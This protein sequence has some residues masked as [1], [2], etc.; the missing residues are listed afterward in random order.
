M[1]NPAYTIFETAHELVEKFVIHL[2]A[3][4]FISALIVVKGC[5]PWSLFPKNIVVSSRFPRHLAIE[6]ADS[7][8]SDIARHRKFYSSDLHCNKS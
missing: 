7:L 3:D 8:V 4:V 1:L 2:A 6:A 5:F